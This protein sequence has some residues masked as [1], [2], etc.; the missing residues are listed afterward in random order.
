MNMIRETA[1]MA[2]LTGLFLAVGYLVGLYFGDVTTFLTLALVLAAVANIGS[3]FF[4][5]RLVLAMTGAK[6]L[7]DRSQSPVVYEVVEGLSQKAGIPTPKIA[8]VDTPVPNAFATGRSPENAVVAVTSGLE[9]SLS[10]DE[11][12]GVIGHEISHV[13]DRDILISAMAATIAGAISYLAYITQWNLYL[14]QGG[15]RRDRDSGASAL[16]LLLGIILVPIAATLI[17]LAISRSRE[18][19]ADL[20]GA[21]LS[22]KPLALASALQRIEAIAKRRPIRVNPSTSSLWI[23]SPVSG[24]SIFELFSTHPATQKRVQRLHEMVG[25]A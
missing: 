12:E 18:Y 6:V 14:G 7:R 8:V 23:I 4:S 11:M 20:N 13:L 19:M 3:Y 25:R 24:T 17:R 5:D 16:F 9:Q 1:L 15:G 10:R 21:K 22:G 2:I